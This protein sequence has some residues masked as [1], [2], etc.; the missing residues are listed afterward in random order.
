MFLGFLIGYV[1]TAPWGCPQTLTSDPTTGEETVSLSIARVRLGSSIQGL[2]HS[3]QPGHRRW[4]QGESPPWSPLLRP[5]GYDVVP[6]DLAPAAHRRLGPV[7]LRQRRRSCR[8][9]P[10]RRVAA[11]GRTHT[12]PVHAR[13]VR[14]RLRPTTHRPMA[15][16]RTSRSRGKRARLF[17]TSTSTPRSP[18]SSRRNPERSKRVASRGRSTRK[19]TSDRASESPRA[20]DPKIR[21]FEIPYRSARD[22]MSA[23]RLSTNSRSR[24]FSMAP[25]FEDDFLPARIPGRSL[26]ALDVHLDRLLRRDLDGGVLPAPIEGRTGEV[27]LLG[28]FGSTPAFRLGQLFDSDLPGSLDPAEAK[29]LIDK[30]TLSLP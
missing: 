30:L 6:G 26:T 16:S 1:L 4:W 21:T 7:A 15:S 12:T 17:T 10:R 20:T 13:P 22:S 23:L 28:L 18:D 24:G 25:P 9:P 11:S 3:T 14:E 2:N 19:S 8:L 29:A 27:C 5:V